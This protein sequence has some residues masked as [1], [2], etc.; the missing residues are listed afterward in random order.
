LYGEITSRP[1]NSVLPHPL[2]VIDTA[3][4]CHQNKVCF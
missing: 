1:V 2:H 3:I 4:L